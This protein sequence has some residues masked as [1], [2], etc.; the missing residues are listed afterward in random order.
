MFAFIRGA[1]VSRQ[2][3]HLVIENQG[4][5]YK[6]FASPELM[7][8]FPARGE[9]TLV[10][11][12][13]YIR[14]DQLA[15]YGFPS[16]E[17]LKL[18]ELLLTVSGVGPKVASAAVGTF[19]PG[20]FAMAVLSGDA[21]TLTQVRGIGR[22]G[23]ERLILELKDKLKGADIPDV[24]GSVSSVPAGGQTVQS[25][26][27]SALVVLGYSATEATQAVQTASGAASGLEDLI[28]LALRQLM[29]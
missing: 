12:S 5:G 19:T 6:I 20:Q 28:R 23:A 8:R 26:A 11:T 10:H 4:I 24:A 9:T 2:L 21:K 29:R 16:L 14:E 3:D 25:E 7:A 27:V 1:I 18:F 15:L 22:K 13:L 17:D